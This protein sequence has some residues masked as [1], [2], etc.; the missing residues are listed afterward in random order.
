[1]RK[2]VSLP[3]AELERNYTLLEVLPARVPGRSGGSG[4]LRPRGNPHQTPWL[5][6]TQLSHPVALG[7]CRMPVRRT[8]SGYRVSPAAAP[9]ALAL[10]EC[11]AHQ[12]LRLNRRVG[13]CALPGGVTSARGRA[14]WPPVTP[15]TTPG[16][17]LECLECPMSR[18]SFA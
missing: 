6:S 7:H 8:R 14:G 16:C 12:P 10:A 13:W 11:L 15:A 4:A 9:P 18:P 1:M 17:K 3:Q 5:T 2:D